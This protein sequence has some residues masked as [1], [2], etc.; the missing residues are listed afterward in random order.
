M[1]VN[2][3]FQAGGNTALMNTSIGGTLSVGSDTD[4]EN[5][6]IHGNTTAMGGVLIDDDLLIIP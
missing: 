5:L 3:D 6:N 4:L 2:N 1:A